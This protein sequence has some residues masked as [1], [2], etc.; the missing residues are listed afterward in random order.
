MYDEQFDEAHLVVFWEADPEPEA[1]TEGGAGTSE[2][3]AIGANASTSNT[4]ADPGSSSVST[5]GT[6]TTAD[7]VEKKEGEA[8]L[9]EVGPGG[10]V[11]EGEEEGE[12]KELLRTRVLYSIPYQRQ[13]GMYFLF[14]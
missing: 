13:Q 8:V 7:G 9:E 12:R 5:N 14:E 4:T 10:F 2:G 6:A 11:R 3:G 1:A